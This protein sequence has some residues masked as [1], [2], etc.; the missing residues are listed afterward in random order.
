MH[1]FE[2]GGGNAL[3]R[4]LYMAIG[5]ASLSCG[6]YIGTIL[7][8]FLST[9]FDSNID[10]KKLHKPML[11]QEMVA[12]VIA[13]FVAYEFTI[14]FFRIFI[15]GVLGFPPAIDVFFEI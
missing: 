2:Y 8:K 1:L 10:I 15:Y 7:V 3:G 13:C 5:G 4:I 12:I 14:I 11:A 9:F 6:F